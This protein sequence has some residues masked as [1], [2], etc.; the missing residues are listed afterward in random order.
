[1]PASGYRKGRHMLTGSGRGSARSLAA[2]A[3]IAMLLAAVAG[4]AGCVNKNAEALEAANAKMREAT[5]LLTDAQ[6]DEALER[7]ETPEQLKKAATA[8]KARLAEVQTALDEAKKAFNELGP[9]SEAGRV[10]V[11][12]VD[13][14]KAGLEPVDELYGLMSKPESLTEKKIDELDKTS[15]E[16]FAKAEALASKGD[17]LVEEGKY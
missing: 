11:S 3:V 14:F 10:Y 7:A 15:Q 13:E 6:A 2:V 5:V 16:H 1:M 4:L 17:K 12:A 8:A 9:D